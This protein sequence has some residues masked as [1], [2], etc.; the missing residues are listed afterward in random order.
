MGR[1]KSKGKSGTFTA[2]NVKYE[3]GTVTSNRRVPN[4]LLDQSFGDSVEALA[5]A[6]IEAQDAEIARRSGQ[7]RAGIKSIV[8][9]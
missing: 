9:V 7:P 4:E 6:A 3:D 2:F 8:P 1:K 5:R